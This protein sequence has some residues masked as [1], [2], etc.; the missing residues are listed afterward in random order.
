MDLE[1]KP[2]H[3]LSEARLASEYGVSRTPVREA[4]QRLARCNLVS[5][6]P[7]RGTF[8]SR[9]DIQRVR[10]A[11]FIVDSLERPLARRAAERMTDTIATQMQREIIMQRTFA[12][13]GDRLEFLASDDHFHALLAKAAAFESIWEDLQ[14]T[15]F[16][17]DRIR[18]MSLISEAHMLAV[19]DKHEAILENLVARDPDLA[20]KNVSSHL[21]TIFKSID[22]VREQHPD[23]FV[24]G[25]DTA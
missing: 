23:Y 9:I 6:Y 17:M 24:D 4:F 3:E 18:R 16:H 14:E 7:Q 21:E 2:Q 11:H 1:I 15:K 25:V 13:F 20:E 12:Q 5:I 8:V 22:T 10:K 19:A